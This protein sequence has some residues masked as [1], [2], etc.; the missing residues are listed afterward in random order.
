MNQR[1]TPIRFGAIVNRSKSELNT[2][3]QCIVNIDGQL[4]A[5]AGLSVGDIVSIETPLG[6]HTLAR[7]GEPIEADTGSRGIR[8]DRLQRQSIKAK[9]DE[10]VK[11]KRVELGPATRVVLSPPID[12]SEAHHLLE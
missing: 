11:V 12:V 2:S 10:E 7:V 3:S 8:L 9:L 4:M 5:A 6:R 1:A